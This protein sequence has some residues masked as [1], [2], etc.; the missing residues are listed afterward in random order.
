MSCIC[1]SRLET[2]VGVEPG[3]S[4]TSGAGMVSLQVTLVS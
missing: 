3:V 4:I 2:Q 1:L